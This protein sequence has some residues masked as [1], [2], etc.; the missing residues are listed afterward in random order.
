M[1]KFLNVAVKLKIFIE[2]KKISK[3]YFKKKKNSKCYFKKKNFLSVENGFF[4]K[5]WQKQF[6]RFFQL[7]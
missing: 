3:C 2:K 5:C 1:T 6:S 4:S 7:F